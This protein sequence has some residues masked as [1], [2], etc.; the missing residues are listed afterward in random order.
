MEITSRKDL[1]YIVWGA[2]FMGSG[3]GGPLSAAL[4]MIDKANSNLEIK[5]I[6]DPSEM[7]DK[8]LAA[9]VA[10][11]GAPT[12]MLQMDNIESTI[13]SFDC[14]NKIENRKIDYLIPGEIGAISM[15][16]P[17]LLSA[18][19]KLGIVDGDGAGRAV[20]SLTECVFAAER[21][22][23]NPTVIT[24]DKN[25]NLV[26]P[27][28]TPE[29]IEQIGRGILASDSFDQKG[30]LSIWVMNKTQLKKAFKIRRSLTHCHRIGQ[31]L[32]SQEIKDPVSEACAYLTES[33][34]RK[35][36]IIFEG[37]LVG[38]D[39]TTGQGFDF[40][41]IQFSNDHGETF[42]IYNQNENLIA[43]SSKFT[44]PIVIAPDSI[45][46]TNKAGKPYT[47][48]DFTEHDRLEAFKIIKIKA[49]EYVSQSDY[50]RMNF[51]KALEQI[52]YGGKYWP[53]E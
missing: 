52:G 26:I 4:S 34:G 20:P 7:S 35:A 27:V 32:T 36:E 16:V 1:L 9:I 43:W 21:L 2:C 6:E 25:Q 53:A 24:D 13:A 37:K 33:A 28:D 50:I 3:G 45:S 42:T 17:L 51:H 29:E 22:S 19:N 31:I 12:A 48:A 5:I 40:G 30:S 46:F 44:T 18:N 8:E 11:M 23:T 41:R 38:Q 39:Q 14:L 15:I 47:N 49:H 10:I